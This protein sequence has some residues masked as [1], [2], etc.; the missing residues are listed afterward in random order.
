MRETRVPART[1]LLGDENIPGTAVYGTLMVVPPGGSLDTGFDLRL[2][3]SVL[4]Q[5][6][7]ASEPG[8][9]A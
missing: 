3:Q 8:P 5:D 1:D 7:Q 4:E 9:T 6:R 2:P